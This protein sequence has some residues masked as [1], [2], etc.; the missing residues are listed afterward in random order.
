MAQ[1]E[2]HHA[3]EPVGAAAA[4][5]AD[6]SSSQLGLFTEYVEHPAVKRLRETDLNGLSPM[7]AFDL[8]RCLKEEMD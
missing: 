2:V 6:P 4:N 7:D 5:T 8:L 3:P 1:L